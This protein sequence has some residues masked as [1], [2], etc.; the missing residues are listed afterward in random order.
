MLEGIAFGFRHHLDVFEERGH[1]PRRVRVT[2]GGS[3]SRVWTQI[4][5]DVLGL[6][7]EK[8]TLRSGSAFAAAFAAGIGVGAFAEWRDVERFISVSAVV[9]PQPNAAYERNYE[10]YRAC[11]PALKEVLR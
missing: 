8:V 2:D 3:R 1:A 5:A 9:E 11:Y 6:P 7:L 10:Q 4:T